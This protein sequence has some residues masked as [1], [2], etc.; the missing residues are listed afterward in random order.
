MASLGRVAAVTCFVTG[1]DKVKRITTSAA[2]NTNNQ[3]STRQHVQQACSGRPTRSAGWDFPYSLMFSRQLESSL[4]MPLLF[5]FAFSDPHG[6][7]PGPIY[8]LAKKGT[9]PAGCER[10]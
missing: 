8:C 2:H 9:I 4:D 10:P 3:R 5:P 7:P 1:A 6:R